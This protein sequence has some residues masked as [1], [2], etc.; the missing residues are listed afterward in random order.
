VEN[1]FAAGDVIP[2]PQ[3]AIV[4]AASGAVAALSIHMSLVPEERRLD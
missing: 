4:A 2:G 1:V 3:M